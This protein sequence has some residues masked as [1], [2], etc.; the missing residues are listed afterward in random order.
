[1]ATE[2]PVHKR[3]GHSTYAR[4]AAARQ[5]RK[6][7][8]A[9][10]FSVCGGTCPPLLFGA[11]PVTPASKTLATLAQCAQGASPRSLPWVPRL[12]TR[13]TPR[14]EQH[15]ARMLGPIH[16]VWRFNSGAP[17]AHDAPARRLHASPLFRP[18]FPG[19]RTGGYTRAKA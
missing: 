3:E 2:L 8:D 10:Y 11:L 7:R 16:G 14:P 9:A 5:A 15:A 1:M 19:H 12:R 18:T 4:K 6:D 13:L 17:S